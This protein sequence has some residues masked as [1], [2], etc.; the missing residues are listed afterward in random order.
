MCHQRVAE[1]P[2]MDLAG[3]QAASIDKY[4]MRRILHDEEL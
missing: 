1:L 4:G 2:W 3:V